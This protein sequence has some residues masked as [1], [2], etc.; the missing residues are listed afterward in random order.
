MAKLDLKVMTVIVEEESSDALRKAVVVEGSEYDA[1]DK[2]VIF[3]QRK[4]AAEAFDHHGSIFGN[5][6]DF[7]LL[8]THAQ[9]W[10]GIPD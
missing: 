5:F 6:H 1:K 2:G 7:H 4:S 3:Y 9:D 10:A 8:M